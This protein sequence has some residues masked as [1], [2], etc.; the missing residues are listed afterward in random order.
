MIARLPR[1]SLWLALALVVYF[2]VAVFG[3]KFGLI[4]W[5]VG[6]LTMVITLGPILMGIVALVALIALI[7]AFVKGPRGEWWKA[8]AALAIPVALFAGLLSVRAQ[9]EAVPPIHD[10]AT[11]TANPPE[12]SAATLA[13]RESFGANPVDDYTTPLNQIPLWAD[14]ERFRSLPIAAKNHAQIIAESYG[15]LAPIPYPGSDADAMAAVAAAMKDIGLADVRS[16][17]GRVEGTA[18]TFLFG[19]KDDVVARVGEGRID[20][21]SVS[22]VGVSD[23]GYNAARVRELS[24]AINARLGG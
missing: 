14:S 20:L 18:E 7:M 9:G 11:D 6:F 24:K 8:A 19:F 15:D 21:R 10:V 4:D 16:D 22:R 2:L 13:M 17:A 3:P 12:F 1:I 23:L 5:K